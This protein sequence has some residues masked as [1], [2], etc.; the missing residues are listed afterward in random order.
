MAV[1]PVPVS[2]PLN[3]SIEA[4]PAWSVQ[5]FT[6]HTHACEPLMKPEICATT[7]DKVDSL[8]AEIK[9]RK[10]EVVKLQEQQKLSMETLIIRFQTMWDLF[11][12]RVVLF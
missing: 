4:A 12:L 8:N 2:E 7:T 1:L 6:V 9:Q 11:E 3:V 5:V 10:E